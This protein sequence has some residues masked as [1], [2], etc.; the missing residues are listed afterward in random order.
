MDETPDR[1][2]DCPRCREWER[3]VCALERELAKQAAEGARL[4]TRLEELE[5]SA[6]RQ[7]VRFA[8]R[9]RVANPKPPGRKGGHQA[10]HRDVPKKVD[11]IVDMPIEPLCPH[12][13]HELDVAT[14]TQYQ[15]DIPQ[16]EPTVTQFNVEVGVCPSCG[17]RVQGRH[18][19]QTSD[20]LGAANHTLGPHV[21]AMAASLKYGAGMSFA[22]IS[23]FLCESFR[24]PCVPSTFVRAGRRIARKAEPTI[25][26]LRHQLLRSPWIHAD[27][28]G[29]RIGVHSTWLWV[30]ASDTITLFDIDRR[31]HDVPERMLSGFDGVLCCDGFA[32]YDS[33]DHVKL[34]CNGHVLHRIAG[35]KEIFG[36]G[37]HDATADEMG[38][39]LFALTE[40]EAIFRQ[41]I[42][43]HRRHDAL[44]EIGFQRR[45]SEIERR[46][47]KWLWLYEEDAHPDV[48]RLR[49]HLAAHRREWF[50]YLYNTQLPTTNNRG[51]QQIRPGVITRRMGGCN[52]TATGAL[53]T[54]TLASLVASCRQQRKSLLAVVSRL[55]HT[56]AP[57]AIHLSRLPAVA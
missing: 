1:T 15:T 25:G 32:A 42:D 39:D 19:E 10:E 38:D 41:A 43:V 31:S 21:H 20:A 17:T 2:G 18:P 47:D 29:W 7:T 30:F 6:K 16:V 33:L 3:R 8:R 52:K 35:L 22:K 54:K 4:R 57:T 28:T 24:L 13:R 34:R 48:A 9:K 44:T 23:R 40:I 56:R 50:L 51:E 46:F 36:Q 14:H 27:E 49:N 45:R 53:A 55:L 11:R 5:R 37:D 26:R 12:C